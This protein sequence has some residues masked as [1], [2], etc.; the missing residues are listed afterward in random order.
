[1]GWILLFLRSFILTFDEAIK[2]VLEES[3]NPYAKTYARALPQA[4]MEAQ[5]M[6]MG[7]DYGERLQI[8]YILSNLQYWRGDRAREVKAALKAR[9]KALGG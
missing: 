9:H 7:A 3:N 4:R 6:G 2:A 1:M 8:P 5:Q